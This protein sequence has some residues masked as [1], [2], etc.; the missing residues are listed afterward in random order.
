MEQ[1]TQTYEQMVLIPGG[2]F[3]MGSNDVESEPDAP[4]K[5]WSTWEHLLMRGA[6]H[7]EQPVHTVNVSQFYM[8]IYPVTNAQYKMFLDANPEWRKDWIAKDDTLY[9]NRWNGNNYPI[10]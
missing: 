2:E 10:L 9:L 6:F 7:D 4:P 8:D 5:G 3:E 1:V